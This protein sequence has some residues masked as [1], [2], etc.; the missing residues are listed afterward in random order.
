MSM[1]IAT[2]G[3]EVRDSIRSVMAGVDVDVSCTDDIVDAS[4]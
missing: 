1:M 4:R 2:F 3:L